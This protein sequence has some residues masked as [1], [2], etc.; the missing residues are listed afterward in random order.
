MKRFCPIILLCLL[1]ATSA[2]AQIRYGVMGSVQ[3]SNVAS[4]VDLT[5]LGPT[6]GTLTVPI[7]QRVGFRVGLMADIPLTD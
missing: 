2:T 1:A 3:A 4:T 5:S 6:L 7:S